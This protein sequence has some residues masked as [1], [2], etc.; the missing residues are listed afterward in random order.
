MNQAPAH[1]RPCTATTSRP[2]SPGAVPPRPTRSKEACTKTAGSNRS[3][4][5]SAPGTIRDGSS[6]AVACDHYHRWPQDLDL[7]SELGTNAYRFSIA[8]PRIWTAGGTPNAQ[9]LDFYDRLVD[10]M[11][12]RGLQPWPTLYHWDLPQPLQDRGGWAAR[13]T[14]HAFTDYVDAV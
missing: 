8:W 5:V 4:T 6:G 14:V 2:A 3:G 11:L 10:G 12:E 1:C 7:A 13:D 9:G